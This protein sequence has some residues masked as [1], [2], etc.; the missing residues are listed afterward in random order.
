MIAGFDQPFPAVSYEAGFRALLAIPI[1]SRHV[2]SVVLLVSRK[3]AEPFSDNEI[4]LLLTFANYATLAWEHAVLYERSDE[5]LREVAKENERLYH[6]A[7]QASQF[8]STLLAAVGHELRTPLAAIKGHATTLLQDD[9]V[10]SPDDQRHFLQTIS[11]E[12]DRLASLVS[13]LLDLSRLEAGLLLLQPASWSLD[14]LLDGALARLSQ[15]IPRLS[16][17]I[18][19]DLPSVWA[20]RPRVEVVLLN[21]LSNALAYGEG[22]IWVTAEQQAAQ[23]VVHLRNDGP[24]IAPEELPHIFDRFYRAQ[25][26]VQRRSG[27]TGLGLA[28]CKAFVE[29]H[30]GRI[31]AESDGQGTTMSFTLPIA[32]PADNA[33]NRMPRMRMEEEK[34]R[35]GKR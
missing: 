1:V 14:E 34:V 20:D 27:G 15:P 33:D 8:K 23:V 32:Q 3:R 24:G 17:H 10:W 7:M 28:I 4:G 30:G 11:D 18:P 6:E 26:G 9:V 35:A 31:W 2:G 13:N 5:R 16:R 21:L 25:R 12:A 29:A 22:S 19:P